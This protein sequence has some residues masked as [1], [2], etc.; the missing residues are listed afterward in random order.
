MKDSPF[1][2]SIIR[3]FKNKYARWSFIIIM[4]YVI[5][6]IAASSGLICKNYNVES[7]SSYEPPSWKHPL[8]TDIFGRDVLSRVIYGARISLS[9]GFF[10]SLISMFI[11]VILG[12]T[13]GFFGG[14]YDDLIV[15]LYS[16]LS[17][18]PGLLLILALSLVLKGKTFLGIPL[19]GLTTVYLAIGLISWVGLCRIIRA[20]VLKHKNREYVLASKSFGASSFRQIFVHILPNISHLIIIDFSLRF[21]GAVQSEVI[22]SFLGLGAVDLPSWGIMISDARLSLSRG[23][24]WEFAGASIAMFILVLSLNIFGDSLR[25]SFDPKMKGLK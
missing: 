24:W 13:A 3:L 14:L 2:D 20:E 25:D 12:A 19:G 9:V 7:P 5:L 17:S 22:I 21:V 8:G 23:V 10:S 18:I 11:G 16:T 1:K 6:A 4:I 15:F